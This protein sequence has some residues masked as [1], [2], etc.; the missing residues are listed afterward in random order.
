MHESIRIST[1][2]HVFGL[3]MQL[4]ELVEAVGGGSRGFF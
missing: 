3:E 4:I 2:V 1:G